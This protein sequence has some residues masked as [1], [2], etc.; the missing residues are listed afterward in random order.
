MNVQSKSIRHRGKKVIITRK[1]TISD[2][3]AAIPSPVKHLTDDQI[4]KEY[5]IMAKPPHKTVAENV[6]HIIFREGPITSNQIADILSKSHNSMS[7]LVAELHSAL[8]NSML[9]RERHKNS[10]A[11]LYS[12]A[13]NI[14][15]FDPRKGYE[16]FKKYKTRQRKLKKYGV[17]EK[18][19]V[20]SIKDALKTT[21]TEPA[22]YTSTAGLLENAIKE[23]A[24]K[25]LGVKVEVSG[26][27]EF[28]FKLGE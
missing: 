17:G 4:R 8:K 21:E 10:K 20:T 3:V 13:D 26:K 12:R 11:Y 15:S 24:E 2:R 22:G 19:P 23:T 16:K 9:K 18:V 27:I 7:A 28:I 6:L 14:I 25:I 1:K 5:G